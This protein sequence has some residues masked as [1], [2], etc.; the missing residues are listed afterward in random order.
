MSFFDFKA[1]ELGIIWDIGKRPESPAF[2]KGHV[3][4]K[5]NNKGK[6]KYTRWEVWELSD[7]KDYLKKLQSCEN[8]MELYYC[9]LAVI[10]VHLIKYFG[11]FF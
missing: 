6:Q 10:K 3:D 8:N 2:K 4:K 11:L 1:F 5:S 7:K 9:A